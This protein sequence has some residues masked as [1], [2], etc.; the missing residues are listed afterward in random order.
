MSIL[1]QFVGRCV[2]VLAQDENVIE[3]TGKILITA[4]VA[5]QYGLTD[6]DGKNPKSQRAQLW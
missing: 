6:I 2:A 1:A 3:N 5:E 4:E